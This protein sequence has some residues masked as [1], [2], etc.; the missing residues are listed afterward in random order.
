VSTDS[1]TTAADTEF[2]ASLNRFR[3][4]VL[5]DFAAFNTSIARIQ[6]LLTANA[7]ERTRY[8]AEKLKIEATSQSVRENTAS[9][10]VQLD[11]AQRTLAVRKTYDVLATR[12]TSDKALRPRH[13]QFGA[14]E[15]LRA[16]IEYLEREGRECESAWLE[17]REMF[18]RVVGEGMRLRRLVR[19]EKEE[20][21]VDAEQMEEDGREGMLYVEG[22]GDRGLA[23][24]MATPRPTTPAGDSGAMTPRSMAREVAIGTPLRGVQTEGNDRVMT[25]EE[26]AGHPEELIK[27]NVIA[28]EEQAGDQMDTS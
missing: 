7:T 3:R 20:A 27:V 23:S 16:E 14:I 28:A 10:R 1:N 2:Q 24:G 18:G 4:D 17:R 5:H 13:E 21:E 6:F 19:G 22:D 25:D 15:K 12:I 26:V 9:L 8:A 11:E